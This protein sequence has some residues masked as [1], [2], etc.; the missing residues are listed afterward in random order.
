MMMEVSGMLLSKDGQ[1]RPL[2]KEELG[3]VKVSKP[4]A[5]DVLSAVAVLFKVY[6]SEALGTKPSD[7]E[8]VAAVRRCVASAQRKLDEFRRS[9]EKKEAELKQRLS[10]AQRTL[11]AVRAA[12]AKDRKAIVEEFLEENNFSSIGDSDAGESSADSSSSDF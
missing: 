8:H 1:P 6:A 12:E 3:Y 5:W 2:S 10:I 4:R 7:D 11:G 9:Y